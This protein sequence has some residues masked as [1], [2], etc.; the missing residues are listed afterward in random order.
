MLMSFFRSRLLPAAAQLWFYLLPTSS[1]PGARWS[2]RRRTQRGR[3]RE[4]R[5]EN[6][7][8]IFVQLSTSH[9]YI[10]SWWSQFSTSKNSHLY[11]CSWSSQFSTSKLPNW[12]KWEG[13]GSDVK[14]QI[15]RGIHKL[16]SCIRWETVGQ[17][18]HLFWSAW[19]W[20]KS[21]L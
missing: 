16:E 21:S 13:R 12:I 9:L 15:F 5:W 19:D 4:L 14:T 17:N 3:E 2:S 18:N 7:H 1:R 8:F 20:D 11:I 6:C 10:Y